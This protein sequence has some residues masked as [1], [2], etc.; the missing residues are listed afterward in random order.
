[1]S[2]PGRVAESVYRNAWL[3]RDY[4]VDFILAGRSLF[5]YKGKVI[6]EDPAV[7]LFKEL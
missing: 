6:M 2:I 4:R 3:P 5:W 1:M 7:S